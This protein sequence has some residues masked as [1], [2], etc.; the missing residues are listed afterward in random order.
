MKITFLHP[1]L[2]IGGAERLV[3]D[4]ALALKSKNHQVRIVTNHHDPKH[5]FSETTDGSFEVDVVGDKIP[6]SILGRCFALCA[7]IRMMYAA[8]V[9]STSG[10]RPDLVFCD[11]VSACIPILK[12]KGMKVVFYCHFP[13]QLLT[14][15]KS[16]LKKLYRWPLDWFEEKS[17]GMADVILVNSNFTAETFRDTFPSLRQRRLEVLY[18]CINVEQLLRPLGEE[19]LDLKTSATTI[20]LSLNRF[21]R[22]KDIGLAI[23]AME[24]LKK[25]AAAPAAHLI[26]AGGHD[27]RVA[28]NREHLGELARL[29]RLLGLEDAVTFVPSPSDDLK[30]SLLHACTAVLYTPSRE[31]FGIV[32]LEA[33]CLGRPVV[34]CASG[35][36]L[37]TVLDGR[38]GFLCAAAPEAFAERMLALARDKSLAREMGAAGAEHVRRKFSF[39]AFAGRLQEVVERMA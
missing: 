26:V 6:R 16:W 23:R 4:A 30:R 29:A 15:R 3:V 9:V 20:F 7:Y 38:T 17:T 34:A 2:G 5:S 22:K 10:Q 32:P 35:G 25:R 8:Y 1:D 28:E 31:H 14:E 24:C 39:G 27:E 12:W 33:M 13:D 19:K 37:E 21:E 36:P 11:Q 18:P